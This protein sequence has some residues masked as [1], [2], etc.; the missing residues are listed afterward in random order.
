[1]AIQWLRA[2]RAMRLRRRPSVTKA[3]IYIVLIGVGVGGLLLIA[4]HR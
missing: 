4:L 2:D 1:M 3:I